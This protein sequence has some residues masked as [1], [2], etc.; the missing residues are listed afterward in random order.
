M[1][2][3]AYR[4]LAVA[5]LTLAAIGAFAQNISWVGSWNTAL[6]ESKKS[7]KLIMA[8]FFTKWDPYGKLLD[9]QTYTNPEVIGISKKFVPVRLD[10]ETIGAP[11]AKKFRIKNYPTI[12]FIDKNQNVVGTIDGLETPAEFVKHANTFVKD[13][14]DFPKASAKLQSNSKDLDAITR[15]GVIY[16][17]RY[18]IAKAEQLLNRA[19]AIDPQNKTDK[20]SELYGAVGDHYQN[21]S[22]FPTA[23]KY[24]EKQAA[25]S[26]TTDR[27]AYGYLSIATCYL[28]MDPPQFNKMK[29]PLDAAMKL[30]NLKQE[31]RDIAEQL[32]Q[33]MRRGLDGG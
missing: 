27:K 18:E 19:S 15:L 25:M 29:A 10:V 17:N 20:L 30:P 6:A 22:K 21:A 33:Q 11:Q 2:N 31:D 8:S 12:L 5:G 9:Q 14:A 7:D 26:K 3:K 1:K 28:S 13:Y 23:I 4:L 24:F 16:A 32:M